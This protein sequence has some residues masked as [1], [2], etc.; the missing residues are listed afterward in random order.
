MRRRTIALLLL[1][2]DGLVLALA[3]VAAGNCKHARDACYSPVGALRAS[4]TRCGDIANVVSGRLISVCLTEHTESV[5]GSHTW[6][7]AYLYRTHRTETH[8]ST[9]QERGT[10]C[11][12]ARTCRCTGCSCPLQTSKR[13]VLNTSR[14][15]ARKPDNAFGLAK[16]RLHLVEMLSTSRAYRIAGHAA[17]T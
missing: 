2:D 12:C 1:A 14:W 16:R 8:L 10:P 4:W 5:R 11:P 15:G 6:F 3:V 13:C 17:R 9:C 7:C